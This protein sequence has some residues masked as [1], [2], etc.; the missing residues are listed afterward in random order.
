MEEED[1][2]EAVLTGHDS[3]STHSKLDILPCV[4]V[5]LS[6]HQYY[7]RKLSGSLVFLLKALIWSSL[8]DELHYQR[9]FL[10]EK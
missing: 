9:S 10:L 4:E 7:S 5:A 3:L 8:Q 2:L 1:R 6:A